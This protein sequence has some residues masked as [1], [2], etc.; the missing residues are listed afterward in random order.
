MMSFYDLVNCQ[1]GDGCYC[2]CVAPPWSGLETDDI[3]RVDNYSEMRIVKIL[4][5]GINQEAYEFMR[6]TGVE[7]KRITAKVLYTAMDY[8]DYTDPG[9]PDGVGK[10]EVSE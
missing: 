4:V 9:Q 7:F 3:V 5:A 1:T 8:T 2:L 10:A 6:N